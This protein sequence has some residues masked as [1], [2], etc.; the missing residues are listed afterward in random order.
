MKVKECIVRHGANEART[1]GRIASALIAATDGRNENNVKVGGE[2]MAYQVRLKDKRYLLTEKDHLVHVDAWDSEIR[3][4]LAGKA[5]VELGQEH[6]D[7]IEFIRNTY[8][9]R[10]MH[11]N[12]RVIA[13]NLAQKYGPD[14]GT[15]RHFYS[16][17]PKGVQ[18]A[19]AISGVPM[20]GFCF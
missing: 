2:V 1:P 12:P 6:L 10:K 8:T 13:A 17:F 19:F 18:Q 5:G 9:R 20:Q 11:P 14:K 3:D 4:W 15:L 16:L 7:A